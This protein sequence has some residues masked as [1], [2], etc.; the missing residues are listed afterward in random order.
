MIDLPNDEDVIA[1][2]IYRPKERVLLASDDGRGFITMTDDLVAQ[3]KE[4]AT[5]H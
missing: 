1:M 3:N 4:R 5:S 2:M